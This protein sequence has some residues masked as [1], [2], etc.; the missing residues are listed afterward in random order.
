[1]IISKRENANQF[2]TIS[3]V[4]N[5]ILIS[6]ENVMFLLVEME[7]GSVIPLHS[8]PHEQ[9][10]ICLKGKVEFQG[11]EKTFIVEPKTVYVIPPNEK[12]G[13]KPIGEEKTVVLEVFSPPREDY[14]GIVASKTHN[15]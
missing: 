13:A 8:H 12:H 5:S 11:G 3:G 1:M 7:P 2:S 4:M 6:G 15:E 10:G 14:L 9:M